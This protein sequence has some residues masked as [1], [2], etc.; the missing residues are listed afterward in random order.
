WLQQMFQVDQSD[1]N[2]ICRHFGIDA[3]HLA[4]DLT[5]FLESLPAGAMTVTGF[6]PKLDEAIRDAVLIAEE[7]EAPDVRSGHLLLAC[8]QSPRLKGELLKV[9]VEFEG[10]DP[11]VLSSTFARITR[12]SSESTTLTVVSSADGADGSAVPSSEAAGKPGESS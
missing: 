12:G 10:L 9:S 4:A 6:A 2:L 8:L 3:A 5:A 1:L 11:N 7:L